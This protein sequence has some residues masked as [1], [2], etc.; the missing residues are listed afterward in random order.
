M[1]P[2]GLHTEHHPTSL[3]L[4]PVDQVSW[5]SVVPFYKLYVYVQEIVHETEDAD[6]G[7]ANL[8]G[9]DFNHW[10]KSWSKSND[11]L[12]KNHVI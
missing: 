7:L 4:Q 6:A 12:S 2:C 10:F 11:F 5:H 1:E 9:A 3:P 8:N